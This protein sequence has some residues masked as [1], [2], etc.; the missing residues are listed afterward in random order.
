MAASEY[1]STETEETKRHPVK[2]SIYT[3]IAYFFT[4]LFLV[5]PFFIFDSAYV[6]IGIT[7]FNALLIILL[8]SYY[9]SVAKETSFWKRFSKMSL[10]VKLRGL[11]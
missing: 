9:V 10:I 7:L 11:S 2:A 4:V 6:S 3:G 1:L 8:F 5:F